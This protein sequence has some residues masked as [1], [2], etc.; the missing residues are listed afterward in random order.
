MTKSEAAKRVEKLRLAIDK[1]R[2][3]YH[4]L[5]KSE[6]SDAALDALKHEL[7]KLEQE[8]PDLITPDS[9]TQ[10]VGGKPL[11]KFNKVKH[12]ERML[13]MEDVFSAEEFQ[14]WEK[15]NSNYLQATSYKLPPEYF[16]MPKLDGLAISLIYK[17]GLLFS[18]ATRGDGE[19]GEDITQ[20][21]R[22][23]ESI[24]LKLLSGPP[25]FKGGDRGGSAPEIVEIRGEVYIKLK[26]FE[27][28]NREQKK[29][30]EPLHANP[31][32]AAAG[33]VRQLDPAITAT[34][35]L[36][37]CAWDLV[38][39]LGQK[40]QSEEWEILKSLGFKPAPQSDVIKSHREV[41]K[42]WHSLQKKR[43]KIG[44]WIDGLVVRVNDNQLFEKL[45]VVGKTPRGLVAWK[46]PAEEGTTKVL[47]VDWFVGRTGK[48]TPV[49]NVEPTQ[50]VG[51]TVVH[52]TLH[53]PDEIKR[54]GLKLGDTVI[55]TKAGDVIPKITK[56][57]TELRN[58]HEKAIHVPTK[59]PTC[60]SPIV[61]EEGEVDYYCSNKNCFAM[62]MQGVLHAAR[63]FDI[64]GL[65]EK[66]VERFVGLG[67]IRTAPDIF[68]L[69]VADLEGLE[70]FG[71]V[72]ANKLIKEIDSKKSID[73]DK[74]VNGLGI[75]N[76][77]TETAA[78][79]AQAFGSI[80]KIASAT[81]EELEAV[82]NIGAV[83][84]KSIHDYFSSAAA[85]KILTDFQEVG[86]KINPVKKRGGKLA[87]KSFVITGGLESMSRDEAKEK[88][89]ALG[90]D[91]AESVS[92]KTSYVVVGSDPGSK[93]EK[94]KKLGVTILSEA[95]LLAML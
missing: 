64:V 75:H 34:R 40:T 67:L 41:E 42:F 54:L 26:D 32:N 70:K 68:R 18:A 27:A 84:A 74:F 79:L 93:F 43:E 13:S 57:L 48:L 71:E 24:P 82:P 17:D 94:A 63:A 87:G 59:C 90:G 51:T 69:K 15:R 85:K 36:S 73:L 60:D 78:D 29:L 6:I 3:Q 23:I 62:E 25:P 66:I 55:L 33:S 65:G 19:V 38:T 11:A 8:Y 5:D 16:C 72:S 83:V 92:K 2:Y 12:R 45:G 95:E 61:H 52:A 7:Y 10:R 89:R 20:N 86:V 39:D 88:I 76:V 58:G 14:A 31:R 35:R 4:V 21:A 53:N 81:L 77:G 1:Y 46:F 80:K 56:V 47:S 91:P 9:P 28:L 37:F 44:F 22:T 30:G 50:L 49:A